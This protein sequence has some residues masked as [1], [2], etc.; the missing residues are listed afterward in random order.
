M[1]MWLRF[2]VLVALCCTA[3]T[4]KNQSYYTHRGEKIKLQL[5]AE[6]EGVHTL[7]D[8]FSRQES[9]TLLFDELSK[10]AIEARVF[11]LKTNT[12]WEV[13]P[14]MAESSQR[15]FQELRR[16]LEIPG[17]RAFLEKCQA[18]GFERIDAF[19]KTQR[20][21]IEKLAKSWG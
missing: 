20:Q 14:E 9:V 2:L 8:F 12:T 3:C 15:L 6:L 13:P 4:E 18:R 16:V 21:K 7:L 19:E 1:R 11:Q 17:A 5:I 10:V